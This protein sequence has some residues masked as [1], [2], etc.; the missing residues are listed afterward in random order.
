M[1]AQADATTASAVHATLDRLA[2]LSHRRRVWLRVGRLI[3][4]VS[5]RPLDNANIVF[6]AQQVFEVSAESVL[7]PA[8]GLAPGQRE[9]DAVLPNVTL[10]PC[11]IECMPIY[12]FKVE[13]SMWTTASHI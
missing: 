12:S 5:D 9:P 13:P 2:S 10:L 1:T 8:D 11:L 6:D 4:G 7:P 3:D